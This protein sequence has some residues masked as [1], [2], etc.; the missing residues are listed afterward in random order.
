VNGI[1]V[2]QPGKIATYQ[3]IA[4]AVELATSVSE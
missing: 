2:G 3:E 1:K 4:D